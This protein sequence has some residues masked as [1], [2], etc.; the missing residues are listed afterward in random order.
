MMVELWGSLWLQGEA[1]ERWLARRGALARGLIL[2]T[3][4]S[5]IVGLAD[6]GTW[7]RS[8]LGAEPPWQ[9]RE[10]VVAALEGRL[11][12]SPLPPDAQHELTRDLAAWLDAVEELD[13]L[14]RPLGRQA[15]TVIAGLGR[16]AAAPYRRLALWLPYSLA[17]LA[18]ARALGG[19][20]GLERMLGA[21]ALAIV[22]HLLDPLGLVL[23]IG[24]VLRLATFCWGALI[25]VRAV[26]V[27]HD[28]DAPHALLAVALPGAAVLTL[29]LS[30][31]S[32]ALALL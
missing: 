24:P 14:P 32:A 8:R 7:V 23:A 1:I 6:S 9:R 13:G 21:S 19:R 22:P 12:I 2:L 29:L 11:A 28:L 26:A 30:A 5:F 17:V 4:V 10:S 15:S 27:A 20:G 3:V 25:Y 31:V 18:V 16:A